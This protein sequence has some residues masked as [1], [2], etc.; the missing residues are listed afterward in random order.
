MKFTRSSGILLHPISLPGEF[1]IGDLG[2][3]SNQFVEFLAASGQQL[4]QVLPLGQ[5]GY[6]DSPYQCFSVFAGNTLLVSPQ[7]LF[8]SGLVSRDDVDNRPTFPEARIDYAQA[9]EF[10]THLLRKAYDNFLLDE[11]NDLWPDFDEFCSNESYWLDD[12]ALFR[13]IK[14]SQGEKAWYDWDPKLAMRDPASIERAKVEF[15]D[16]INA[17]KF[18]QFL[19]FTQWFAIKEL[20]HDRGISIIGD[21]PIFV[22]HDSVDVWSNPHLFKLDDA[23]NPTVVA[24]VPPDYFSKTGQLWGNPIY[25]WERMRTDGFSWWIRRIQAMFRMFD[26]VRLDHFRGFVAAWEVPGENKTAEHGEWVSAP[27]RELFAAIHNALGE[28]PIIVED[29]GFITPEVEA[30]RDEFGFAGMRIL[31]FAFG[32]DSGSPHLPHKYVNNA[33]VYTGTHDNDTSRG[34]F[35]SLK[36]RK[37]TPANEHLG[38]T[39]DHCLKYLKSHGREIHWDMI[40]AAEASVA[41]IAIIPLQDVLGLGSEGRM[42]L[43]ATEE[44]NWNWRLKEGLLTEKLS[45]RLREMCELYGR[46]AS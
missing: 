44:G 17:Q 27:G 8:D 46:T 2:D 32:G 38:R 18:Y 13:A 9:K 39:R 6:G 34:W 40:R 11:V 36:V 35:A 1:G 20:C 5:T 7:R 43:P 45:K 4:W 15:R 24:G 14:D 3:H 19:F 28:L 10:K 33:V 42:N 12:W 29:L 41:D 21:I 25:D 31:Q 37:Q 26:I 16:E 23:R 22:A 30:L